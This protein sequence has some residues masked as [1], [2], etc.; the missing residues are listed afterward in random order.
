MPRGFIVHPTSPSEALA[1]H[2]AFYPGK[3]DAC[4]VDDKQIRA[5]EGDFYGGCITSEARLV[6]HCYSGMFLNFFCFSTVSNICYIV[7]ATI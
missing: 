2:V 4:F 3:M 6:G 5:Q 1:N 7:S